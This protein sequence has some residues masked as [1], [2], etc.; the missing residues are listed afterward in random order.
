M[1]R[2]RS[3]LLPC[4]QPL[5]ARLAAAGS[6]LQE[7][8]AVLRTSEQA[9]T[10]RE[11]RELVISHNVTGKRSA[12]SREKVWRQLRLRYV[13]DPSVGESQAF[14]QGMHAADPVEQG[15]L[16]YLM[17][18]RTDRLFREVTLHM[19]SPKLSR[20]GT[21]VDAASVEGCVR[22][23]IGQHGAKWS[24][25]TIRRVQQHILAAQKDFGV[26]KGSRTRR[27]VRP[28]VGP[29]VTLFA[30]RLALLAGM[31][32]RQALDSCW[33]RLLGLDYHQTVEALF[34]ATR[35]GALSFRLQADVAELTLPPLETT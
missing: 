16:A 24:P 34:A 20:E 18:A 33:F 17:F 19:I 5:T 31:T 26:V 14:V 22:E 4:E 12:V 6:R 23:L 2:T 35:G 8:H 25:T 13:L 27:T 10:P 1:T 3:L 29:Q 11:M 28:R 32:D 30:S 9:T 7:L 21:P 15:L